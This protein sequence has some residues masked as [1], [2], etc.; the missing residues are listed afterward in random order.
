M[1]RIDYNKPFCLFPIS[2]EISA[3]FNLTPLHCF[4]VFRQRQKHKVGN[5]LVFRFRFVIPNSKTT[6]I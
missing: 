1:T 2:P 6:T 5:S 4:A 3:H